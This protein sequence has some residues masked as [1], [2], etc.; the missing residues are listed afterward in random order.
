M[1]TLIAKTR[2]RKTGFRITEIFSRAGQQASVF[3][4]NGDTLTVV[5]TP[6]TTIEVGDYAI[7]QSPTDRYHCKLGV[8]EEQYDIY[9]E[10][11]EPPG[12]TRG[13]LKGQ[14]GIGATIV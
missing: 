4:E 12:T 13:S 10:G 9:P 14:T 8:V 6:G 5:A 3:L 7:T 11:V 1:A 2:A